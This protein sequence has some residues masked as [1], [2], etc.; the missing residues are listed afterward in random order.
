M[1][2]TLFA[3]KGLNL[4]TR[5]GKSLAAERD[6]IMEVQR[7]Y[8]WD[9]AFETAI[10]IGAHIGAWTCQAKRVNPHARIVA[11]EVD[12]ET[13]SVLE[14][15]ADGLDGV[16]LCLTTRDRRWSIASVWIGARVSISS[17]RA[18]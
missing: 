3:H 10:D 9:F 17:P 2:L 5:E 4:L 7:E 1:K 18:V 8:P 13:Y 14:F 16:T 6:I 11:C 15:N 12:P